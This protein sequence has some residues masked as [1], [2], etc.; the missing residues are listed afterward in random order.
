MKRS[1]MRIVWALV[2]SVFMVIETVPSSLSA[3]GKQP[4]ATVSVSS[5][6]Y[7]ESGND[8]TWKDLNDGTK[9]KNGT[10]LRVSGT[11]DVL[12]TASSDNEPIELTV[13]L[14]AE[15]IKVDN[16]PRQKIK[17]NWT[18]EFEIKDNVLHIYL[19]ADDRNKSDIRGNF[20]ISGVVD[21]KTDT[22]KD[23]DN[24]TI[25]L[26][27]KTVE[28]KYDQN[29]TESGLYT[30][31]TQ[32]GSVYKGTDGNFYQNYK[33]EVGA[34]NGDVTINKFN[35]VVGSGLSYS[36]KV[37][38]QYP[39]GSPVIYDNFD[40]I[41]ET[42]LANGKKIYITYATK[43]NVNN[44]TDLFDD[45]KVS[46]T[47]GYKNSFDVTYTTNKNN[48]KKD[49][50][51]DVGVTV[52][53]P[54]VS[55][56]GSYDKATGIV[57]WTIT[58]NIGSY[59]DVVKDELSS[60]VKQ[61]TDTMDPSLELADGQPDPTDPS[62]YQE[63]PAGSGIYKLSYQT[64][65]KEG[66][67]ITG[68]KKVKNDVSV[69]FADGDKQASGEVTVTGD[70]LVNKSF[71][72][73]DRETGVLTWNINVKF[74]EGMSS[75]VLT[76]NPDYQQQHNSNFVIKMGD[77]ILYDNGKTSAFTDVFE[78]CTT[79]YAISLK[80]NQKFVNSHVNQSVD[81][82][83]QTKVS[84][85]N[86]IK[87]ETVYSNEAKLNYVLNNQNLEQ[88][89]NS[90]YTYSTI[91]YKEGNAANDDKGT[92]KYTIRVGL[93][94]Y[95]GLKTG[96]VLTI[97]DELDNGYVIDSSS[98]KASYNG[99]RWLT[100]NDHPAVSYSEESHDFTYVV[101]EEFINSVNNK[102][103]GTTYGL[104]IEYN[105]YPSD[106]SSLYNNSGKYDGTGEAEVKNRI[107]AKINDDF[108]GSSL[109]DTNVSLKKILDKNG[110]WKVNGTN[111]N[112]ANWTLSINPM[113]ATLNGGS[114]LKAVDQLSNGLIYD[115]TSIKVINKNTGDELDK[116]QYS[117]AYN[118]S[119]NSLIFT[120]PDRTP[121]EITYKTAFNVSSGTNLDETNSNNSLMLYGNSDNQ[122]S[123]VTYHLNGE[124]VPSMDITG[125]SAN[126]TITKYDTDDLQKLLENAKFSVYSAEYDE[127]NDTMNVSN[128][129][130]TSNNIS[131]FVTDTNG[132]AYVNGLRLDVIY[133]VKETNAPEGYQM[134][135]PRYVIFKGK[136]FDKISI[137][138]DHSKYKLT[139]FETKE[140]NINIGD[141]KNETVTPKGSLTVTKTFE[142]YTPTEEDLSRIKITVKDSANNP[143]YTG[144]LKDIQQE[145]GTFSKTINDLEAGEY[146]VTET[147]ADIEGYERTTNYLVNGSETDKVTVS[148]NSAAD[149]KIQ[150]SYRHK[151][152]S[153]EFTKT[154]AGTVPEG[155][156]SRIQFTVTKEN[157]NVVG[158]YS[159]SEMTLDENGVYHKTIG[160][161]T[162]GKYKVNETNGEAD[163]YKL[164]TMYKVGETETSEAEV[165]DNET[166]TVN[167]TNTYTEKPGKLVIT[168]T[169]NGNVTEEALK[170]VKFTVTGPDNYSKEFTLTSMKQ[171]DG[172]YRKELKDLK[173]GE[174]T[175]SEEN[176]DVEHYVRTTTY[177]VDGNETDGT[178]IVNRDAETD[179][180]VVNMYTFMP[181]KTS[182]SVLKIWDDSD[183]ENGLRPENLTVQLLRDG[184]RYGGTVILNQDNN[185]T[186]TWDDL[187]KTDE[188]LHDYSYSV[189]EEFVEN[190]SEK[191]VSDENGTV[192]TN[193][194]IDRSKPVRISK[195]D[196]D[197]R[198]IA[199]AKLSVLDNDKNVIASW[200]T[201][202]DED[203]E[204]SL[205]PGNYILH[206][207]EAPV[208]YE[209]AE[210]IPFSVD[211][212]GTVLVNGKETDKV[213]MVDKSKSYT[214]A[215]SKVDS[216]SGNKISGA[217]LKLTDAEGNA[218]DEWVSDKDNVHEINLDA[219]T[220]ILSETEAPEGYKL[221]DNI[222]F[223][224]DQYG[225]ITVDGKQVDQI[226]MKDVRKDKI[227]DTGDH[228][229][230][231]LY[232]CVSLAMFGIALMAFITRIKMN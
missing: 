53:K 155:V 205:M 59:K 213:T 13:D 103:D 139:V 126:L 35:D 223:T 77:A 170:D 230:I 31:K 214:V 86:N 143:V 206:E 194:Y 44:V 70:S 78:S 72:E 165:K 183:N 168:K 40:D 7:S 1:L 57:T 219:G 47:N 123:N 124:Y 62:N 60:L 187:D 84:D 32:D 8:G 215:V 48:Q 99:Y 12:N 101:D 82:T 173:A 180:S 74:V 42:K 186:Y 41:P 10:H 79:D 102:A 133:Q 148:E 81:F 73:F 112:H 212:N 96:D 52:N 157:G 146:T 125:Q 105:A 85:K 189:E 136:D 211:E 156:T 95:T 131:E 29:I 160:G 142:E 109:S 198:I 36:G 195:T 232:G 188:Y 111:L 150:N 63:N 121:L 144:K 162:P 92:V 45:A 39:D 226:L 19:S 169:V 154:F 5:I 4:T 141:K 30:N 132:M 208:G 204:I 66:T 15:N 97:H 75:V 90:S 98:I 49:A 14:S 140:S 93:T 71:T 37:T 158:T 108:V 175:V 91:V 221:A 224:V 161:L 225:E 20:N 22:V 199:G 64:K 115:L 200:K 153:L 171:R 27:D 227:I 17:S 120:I 130:F 80:F 192:L 61:I 46:V 58:I 113:G 176:A 87:N 163:G 117:Y 26:G 89:S 88:K 18:S 152:G 51:N 159:L 193:T 127:N 9:V 191:S 172:S 137:P 68:G 222:K 65:L 185:W 210:D 220:Y 145:D 147:N 56:N 16:Y 122:L 201:V 179:L 177:T 50:K 106:I 118:D 217:K 231:A 83:V 178:V 151:E 149:V 34:Y 184:Q 69:T 107:Q 114:P 67:D 6:Q 164:E 100:N 229:H 23:G 207:D 135:E 202:E 128:K 166:A 190:Y 181:E 33:I 110:I 197:G 104:A 203:K 3:E 55:K 38:V 43:L 116:T 94:D 119:D 2:L 21:I 25:K 138:N 228:S 76:D 54:S 216:L 28:V 174:Y 129:P 196:N 11:F 167:I 134:S 182:Y 218:V 209:L 24:V